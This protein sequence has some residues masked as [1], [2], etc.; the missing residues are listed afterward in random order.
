MAY[1]INLSPELVTLSN[2]FTTSKSYLIKD[3][4]QLETGNFS[5]TKTLVASDLKVYQETEDGLLYGSYNDSATRQS[6]D[7]AEPINGPF[8]ENYSRSGDLNLDNFVNLLLIDKPPIRTGFYDF[9]ILGLSF[10]GIIRQVTKYTHY[11][12]VKNAGVY[13]YT[14]IGD[15]G[16]AIEI[17]KNILYTAE[18]FESPLV[19]LNGIRPT[20]YVYTPTPLNLALRNL[21]GGEKITSSTSTVSINSYI[22]SIPGANTKVTGTLPITIFYISPEEAL[23][24]IASYTDL[25]VAYETDYAKGQDH[26]ARSGALEGRS[27]IFDP[28]AYLNKYADLRQLYGYNTY[29]ATVHYITTGYYEGRTIDNASSVNPLSG[30]LYD[31]AS[32]SILSSG[33]FIW[34]N[35]PTIKTSGRNLSYNYNSTSYDS[36]NK[37]DFTGNVQYLRII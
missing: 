7:P 9:E 11:D 27:I 17:S 24:Y 15:L 23:R 34:Q 25:I 28:T 22:Q 18:S 12:W 2:V 4:T 14:N 33:T 26:Y 5:F 36:G 31:I 21:I 20:I 13:S 32:Q 1:L 16:Y 19:G 35:G 6:L 10:T 8:I 30:G 37:V 3:N 29:S